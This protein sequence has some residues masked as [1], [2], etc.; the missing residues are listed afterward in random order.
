MDKKELLKYLESLTDE[1]N[2]V[3]LQ[4][5]SNPEVSGQEEKAANLYRRKFKEKGFKIVDIPGMEHAFY[6]EYGSGHPVIALLGEYDALP[7]LSQKVDTKYN[8][9]EKDGPGHACGHNLLGAAPFG[10]ALAIKEYLDRT[11][12]PGT[13]RYYG[14]PEEET[15]VGKVKMVK[16]EP[17]TAVT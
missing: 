5:W 16:K 6:A 2:E 14:C 1:V 17:L 10:A 9:V 13:I 4:I 12:T 11:N 7:G 3:N 8:P 15:L